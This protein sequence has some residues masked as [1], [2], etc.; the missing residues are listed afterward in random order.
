MLRRTGWDAIQFTKYLH[1]ADNKV[2]LIDMIFD[3]QLDKLRNIHSKF[4]KLD[5]RFK[6]KYYLF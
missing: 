3:Y 6:H 5:H 2:E 4:A 1:N